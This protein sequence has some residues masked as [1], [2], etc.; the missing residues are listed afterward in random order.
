M[1]DPCYDVRLDDIFQLLV[2]VGHAFVNEVHVSVSVVH[3]YELCHLSYYVQ[4]YSE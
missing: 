3:V 1:L 2:N 4:L